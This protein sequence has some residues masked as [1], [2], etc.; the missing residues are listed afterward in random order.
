MFYLTNIKRL[1]PF[2]QVLQKK[3]CSYQFLTEEKW[4]GLLTAHS[5]ADEVLD[6]FYLSA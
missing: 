2:S 6:M 4:D 5:P 3:H 1:K